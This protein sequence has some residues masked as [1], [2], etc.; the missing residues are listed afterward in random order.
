MECFHSHSPDHMWYKGSQAGA[1]LEQ[2]TMCL[3]L[4]WTFLE[5]IYEN[6]ETRCQ[7][8]QHLLNKK[9][10]ADETIPWTH[11]AIDRVAP[12]EHVAFDHHLGLH[13]YT[14]GV[15]QGHLNGC[16]KFRPK[17]T[18]ELGLH[19][20]VPVSFT[21]EVGLPDSHI[22]GPWMGRSTPPNSM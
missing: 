10:E 14:S 5:Q 11:E 12:A 4:V 13:L 16:F 7:Q 21:E 9:P 22:H 15:P 6:E 2:P 20:V 1:M 18:N 3:L 19:T 17:P 8:C